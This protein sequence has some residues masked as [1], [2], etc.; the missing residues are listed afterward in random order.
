MGA[1]IINEKF[2]R[3]S[4][5][6]KKAEVIAEIYVDTSEEL[7]GKNSLDDIILHQGSAAYV[8]REKKIAVMDSTGEWHYSETE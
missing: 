1:T 7:P 2:I 8:I 3:F 4:E 5:E 6:T